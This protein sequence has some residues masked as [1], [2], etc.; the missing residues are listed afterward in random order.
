MGNNQSSPQSTADYEADNVSEISEAVE[1][2][3]SSTA[4]QETID[5]YRAGAARDND[6]PNPGTVGTPRGDLQVHC[7]CLQTFRPTQEKGCVVALGNLFGWNDPRSCEDEAEDRIEEEIVLVSASGQTKRNFPGFVRVDSAGGDADTSSV[8]EDDNSKSDVDPEVAPE[9]QGRSSTQIPRHPK[10]YFPPVTSGDVDWKAVRSNRLKVNTH[11][12][13]NQAAPVGQAETPKHSESGSVESEDFTV[14]ELGASK[15][16]SRGLGGRPPMLPSKASRG[17]PAEPVSTFENVYDNNTLSTPRGAI[18]AGTPCPNQFERTMFLQK[19]RVASI[20][21]YNNPYAEDF[22]EEREHAL[23]VEEQ[24]RLEAEEARKRTWV[25]SM[26]PRRAAVSKHIDGSVSNVE[27]STDVSS[28]RRQTL[29]SVSESVAFTDKDYEKA[30]SILANTSSDVAAKS[31]LKD[32][33]FGRES[34]SE[35]FNRLNNER[36]GELEKETSK[37]GTLGLPSKSKR[38]DSKR[39]GGELLSE[40]MISVD[41]AHCVSRQ[42]AAALKKRIRRKPKE[43]IGWEV[44]P[45]YSYSLVVRLYTAPFSY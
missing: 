14:P 12:N 36:I 37:R 13:Y 45:D 8:A 23:W 19:A 28:I 44:R 5:K 6:Q 41:L 26:T 15:F 7:F 21:P 3:Y 20:S 33:V 39:Q 32:L 27:S 17:V 35:Q 18:K 9:S 30:E 11:I 24:K 29:R 40:E 16:I 31:D 25:G 43:L 10:N 38:G 34:H 4:H 42:E 1:D 2:D 22:K